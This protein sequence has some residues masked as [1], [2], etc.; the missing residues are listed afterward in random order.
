MFDVIVPPGIY[1]IFSKIASLKNHRHGYFS[2]QQ[3]ETSYFCEMTL[4]LYYK[5]IFSILPAVY[6]RV[7]RCKKASNN[8]HYPSPDNN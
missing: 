8:R 1:K 2:K 7:C 6:N 3:N 5:N 4:S